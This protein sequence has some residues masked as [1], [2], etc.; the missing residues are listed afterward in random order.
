MHARSAALAALLLAPS[1]ASA[2]ARGYGPIVLQLPASTRA[3]GFGNAYVASREAEAVFYNPA[4]AN[5]TLVAVSGERYGSEAVAVAFASSFAFGPAGVGIGAQ[6]LDYHVAAARY[7]ELAPNG[8][9]LTRTGA[10]PASS[11]VAAMSLAIPFKGIRWG[12]AAKVAQD[13]VASTRDG[14]LLADVGA[15]KEVGPVSLG[16][17]VQNL[18]TSARLAGGTTAA[19]PTRATLGFSGGGLPVGP[20]DFAASAAVSVRRGGRVSPAGGGELSYMPIDGIVFAGR[21]G[22]R[23]PEK[24]AELPVTLGASFSFDRLTFDYGFEPYHGDGSGHRVG[25]RI[26]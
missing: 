3:I 11:V 15:A 8:E 9:Q 26:R 10:F 4:N 12:V 13:R 17:T 2:Q 19:L 20:L 22:A 7:P 1:A 14:V 25:L 5:R 16:V 24:G 6:L 21:L 18:G 23:L